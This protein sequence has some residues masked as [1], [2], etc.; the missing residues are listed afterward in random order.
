MNAS[1]RLEHKKNIAKGLEEA[2]DGQLP[3]HIQAHLPLAAVAAESNIAKAQAAG[4]HLIPRLSSELKKAC[5]PQTPAPNRLKRVLFIAHQWSESLQKFSAC[6]K[7]C[8]HCCHISVTIS[9]EEAQ[10]LSHASGRPLSRP[11]ETFP[12]TAYPSGLP[13][14]GTPCP[15]LEEGRCSV[16]ASRPLVCRTLVNMDDSELLCELVE[17]AAVP[18]PYADASPLQLAYLKT[19]RVDEWADIRDWFGKA[20][21][22]QA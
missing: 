14:L 20:A 10:L 9:R 4:A 6:K 8:S 19:V 3:S 13:H 15:F 21:P 17:G 16:Y 5:G 1:T 11:A 12:L 2:G 7:G 22:N 18:V